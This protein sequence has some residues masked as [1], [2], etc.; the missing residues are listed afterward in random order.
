MREVDVY[1][2]ALCCATGV[3]GPELDQRP[4]TFTADVAHVTEA[5]GRI[6]RHNLASD[7]SAFVTDEQV[8]AFRHLAGSEGLPLTSVDGV[9]VLTC[10]YPTRDQLMRF[11]ALAV[12][13]E[14]TLRGEMAAARPAISLTMIA[15]DGPACDADARCC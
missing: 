6:V 15:G 7:P 10:A 5:G 2:P 4:V 8:R 12:G 11:A 1:E 13:T 3:C 9:T 14:E